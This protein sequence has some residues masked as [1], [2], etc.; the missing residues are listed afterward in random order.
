VTPAAR[1]GERGSSPITAVAGVG[2][3][4]GFL[5]LAAQVLLHLYATSTVSAAAFDGARRLAAEEGMTCDEARAHVR[6][7]L[8]DHGAEVAIAC[9]P[10]DGDQVGLRVSGPSPAPLVQGF[11]DGFALGDIERLVLVRD[12]VLRPGG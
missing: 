8:G 3:F 9:V 12:E 10:S 1:P 4:L 2:M 7:L 6:G 5:L 11:R